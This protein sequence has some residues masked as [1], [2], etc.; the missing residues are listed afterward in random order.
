MVKDIVAKHKFARLSPK[1][2]AIVM[3]IARGK[4]LE[5]AKVALAF[6]KTKAAK[7]ILKVVKS[8]EAN[9]VNNEKLNPTELYIS[10]IYVGPGPMYKRAKMGAKGRI[11]PILKRTSHIYIKLSAF[12]VPAMADK[13]APKKVM[14]KDNPKVSTQKKVKRPAPAP[15]KSR[16]TSS[17]KVKKPSSAKASEGKGKK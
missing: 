1:K 9:A 5:K 11:D 16:S 3:D 12:A 7:M 15:A 2:A 8:A 14:K 6:D 13:S 17:G 10:E 4:S